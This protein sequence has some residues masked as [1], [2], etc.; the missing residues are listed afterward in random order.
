MERITK[1]RSV[2]LLTIVALVLAF[3]C[4][5][6]YMM[7]IVDDSA[8]AANR[9]TYVTRTRVRASRGD[10][11]DT[12]GIPE[13]VK[14]LSLSLNILAEREKEFEEQEEKDRDRKSNLVLYLISLFG[15]I[16]IPE[17]V[18]SLVTYFVEKQWFQAIL[19]SSLLLILLVLIVSILI[20]WK[21]K[22]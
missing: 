19:C 18:L 10:I 4:I 12:N 9:P 11:L 22:N 3:F 17:S 1:F 15:I 21:K 16:S 2:L 6:L 14:N 5:K 8:A 13:A 20:F 7:Q